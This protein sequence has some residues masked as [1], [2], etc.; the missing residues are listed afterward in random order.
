MPK[1]AVFLVDGVEDIEF[2]TPVDLLRRGGVEVDT[3]SIA[4][5]LEVKGAKGVAFR[6]DKGFKGFDR[7][8]Y[9]LLVIPG[10]TLAWLDHKPF[11]D[12]IAEAG[13][14]GQKLAAICV[15]PAVFG[16]LGLL[17]G[18]KAVCYPGA[19]DR[20]KGATVLKVPFVTD[21]NIT[22]SRGPGTAALFGLEL[23]RIL[24]GQSASDEVKSGILLAA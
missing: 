4:S 19:E 3:V 14:A 12:V 1:A 22:T 9:D 8:A 7:L 18:K 11:L 23:V 15:A 13:K 5:G 16:E 20:L 17:Q 2:V 10:G 21:G 6:A 24:A